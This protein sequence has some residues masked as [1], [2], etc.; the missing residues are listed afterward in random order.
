EW[1]AR[2]HG[3]SLRA[4]HSCAASSCDRFALGRLPEWEVTGRKV[5]AA[6]RA[7]WRLDDAADILGARATR[8][9]AAA[10]RPVRRGR[11]LAT[12]RRMGLRSLVHRVGQRDRCDQ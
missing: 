3:V 12:Y 5:R 6:E 10:R 9:E 8:V 2:A 4:R 1:A 7:Q 11:N